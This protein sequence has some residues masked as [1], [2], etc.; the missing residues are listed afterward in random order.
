MN[1]IVDG[2]QNVADSLRDV[3]NLMGEYTSAFMAQAEAETKLEQVMR[4]TM[5]ATD[6]EVRSIKELASAQQRLGVIGDEV[7]LAGAQELA[8]YEECVATLAEVVGRFRRAA[9]LYRAGGFD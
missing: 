7:V 5:S 3:D 1:Q 8:T 2:I 4:N 6:A 9:C